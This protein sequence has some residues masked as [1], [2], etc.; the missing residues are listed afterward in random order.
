MRYVFTDCEKI[1]DLLNPASDNMKLREYTV[2]IPTPGSLKPA[3]CAGF[4]VQVFEFV[5][6]N[7]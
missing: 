4:I 3:P 7:A 1:R 5:L 2:E 6:N